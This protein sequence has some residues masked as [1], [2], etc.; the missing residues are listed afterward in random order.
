VAAVLT[1]EAVKA[2]ENK[3][4][5]LEVQTVN[6]NYRLPAAEMAIDR[7]SALLGE[8]VKLSDIVIH[9]GI[10]K[11]DAAKLQLLESSAD[12]GSFTLE[13]RRSILQ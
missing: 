11:S 12:K 10:A 3:Q 6:G 7:V 4:A 9:V 2:M 1:G 5:V 8:Q 13:C